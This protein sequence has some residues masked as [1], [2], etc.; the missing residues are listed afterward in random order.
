MIIH[1]KENGNQDFKVK[2]LFWGQEYEFHFLPLSSGSFQLGHHRIVAYGK[3]KYS[4]VPHSHAIL[5]FCAFGIF[6]ISKSSCMPFFLNFYS[7]SS[8][9]SFLLCER[10]I[11]FQLTDGEE[12]WQFCTYMIQY[13]VLIHIAFI[14]VFLLLFTFWLS[15]LGMGS[16]IYNILFT[17]LPFHGSFAITS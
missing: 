14:G 11:D 15:I 9:H 17:L 12:L 5:H 13:F 10:C 8:I 1:S 16:F 3:H 7:G 4:F 6:V 2:I